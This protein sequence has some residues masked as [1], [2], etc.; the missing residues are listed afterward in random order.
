MESVVKALV[1]RFGDFEL[2]LGAHQLR[3]RG[4]PVRLERRPFEL[5]VLLVTRQGLL[6]SREEIIERLWPS[7]VVIEFDTGLNTLVRKVRQALGDSSGTPAYIETVAGVGYRFIAPVS[8]ADTTA[9]AVPPES[10]EAANVRQSTGRKRHATLVIGTL[11]AAAVVATGLWGT[12]G[13]APGQ[14]S[15]AV[16][17][18]EN[19]SRDEELNYL[20]AGLAEDTSASLAQADPQRLRLMGRASMTAFAASGK[21][22][23]QVGREL[24]VDYVVTSSLRAEGQRIRVTSQLVSSA[25]SVVV[26]TASFD[27]ELTGVL[28]L[29]RELSI[30]I[31]EQVRLRLSPEVRQA[32]ARR[33][34]MNPEAYDLYLRGRYAWGQISPAGNRQ[35]LDYFERAIAR[36][37]DYALAWGGIVHVLSTAPI[38]GE[39]EPSTVAQRADVAVRRALESGGDLAEV[40]VALGYYHF[41]LDWNWAASEAAFRR[42][43]AL[44]PNSAIAHL[45]LGHVVSQSGDHAEARTLARRARELDPFFS[46]I[47]ALSATIAFQAQDFSAAE[48]FARQAVAI[49]PEA[50]VGHLNL[51]QAQSALGEHAAALASFDRALRYSSSNF[52]SMSYRGHVLASMGEAQEA[53]AVIATLAAASRE[54]YVPPYVIALVHAGL[55]EHEEA[56][57]WLER[58]YVARDIHL[59]FLTVDPRWDGLRDDPRFAD[60][61]VRCQFLGQEPARDLAY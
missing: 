58:A 5:L 40:Q 47:F 22:T 59:V 37:P 29:Q 15:I 14:V 2:D 16:L 31:A 3:L 24:G 21:P 10:D 26:W 56:L 17:P 8:Q 52:K 36:D 1:Y 61:L 4:E 50:W 46:H 25:D 42:A 39:V 38:T 54:R 33:Q 28:G 44:D 11:L 55:D 7:N 23:A 60:L 32:V 57:E 34:T 51:G 30:A 13:R 35:A 18:F 43:A 45:M 20:A 12:A 48:E 19:L 6:V 41:F 53:R 49:D 9:G 27:R